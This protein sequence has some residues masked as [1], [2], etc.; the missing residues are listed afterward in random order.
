MLPN[1]ALPQTTPADKQPA[2]YPYG[3]RPAVLP[4]YTPPPALSGGLEPWL[5]TA[6]AVGALFA[7]CLAFN[8]L[9]PIVLFKMEPGGE[10]LGGIAAG[11][12]ATQF[13]ALCGG[14]VFGEGRFWLRLVI[15][16]ALGYSLGIVFL[17]GIS[18]M[19]TYINLSDELQ[20]FC[21]ATPLVALAAQLPLWAFKTYFSWRI[22]RPVENLTRM[23]PLSIGDILVGTAVAAL[24]VAAVRFIPHIDPK[25]NEFW[26][27]W[28][29]GVASVAG[30]SLISIL[31]AVY[32]VLR[33]ESRLSG[34]I[35][36][37]FYTVLAIG[38]TVAI[39]AYVNRKS[40]PPGDFWIVMWTMLPTLAA[41]LFGGLHL[42]RWL[43]YRLVFPGDDWAAAE[44]G[45]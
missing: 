40:P 7:V 30:I 29:I 23:R 5:A 44:A 35:L 38:L 20:A 15:A 24:T 8:A 31:P 28:A 26:I 11:I 1:P 14:L 33:V 12:F 2:D 21:C 16:W 43:G 32:F 25:D 34:T 10:A 17:V 18:Q 3:P 19:Q 22:A 45:R 9:M 37:A 41:R 4:K 27:A 6:I 42:F 13:A 39:I 36:Y